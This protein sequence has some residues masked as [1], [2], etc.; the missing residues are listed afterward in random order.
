MSMQAVIVPCPHERALLKQQNHYK[1]RY[2]KSENAM[3]EETFEAFVERERDR[4]QAQRDA[5]RTQQKELE[6]QLKDLD[7]Q[8]DAIAAYEA[9]RLGKKAPSGGKDSARSRSGRGSK[10]DELM[11]VIVGSQGLSRGEILE[12]MGL[13]G[14]KSRE[15]SI[16]NALTALLKSSQIRRNDQK[17]YVAA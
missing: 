7:R 17:K 13:K 14:N 6:D 15:M 10:R 16:S 8:F 3:A 12:K 11:K 9:A 4:L 1:L 5:I 2:L